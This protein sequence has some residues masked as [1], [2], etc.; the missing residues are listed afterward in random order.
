ML[1]TFTA[2]KCRTFIRIG[3]LVRMD[4]ER[5]IQIAIARNADT[6]AIG[7]RPHPQSGNIFC[8]HLSAG[9]I[10]FPEISPLT[11][12]PFWARRKQRH[13]LFETQ[14]SLQIPVSQH[15][16][17]SR[18]PFYPPTEITS[19]YVQFSHR[20]HGLPSRVHLGVQINGTPV[21]QRCDRDRNL[22]D[23]ETMTWEDIEMIKGW[24]GGKITEL[25][26]RWN[27]RISATFAT[28]IIL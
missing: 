17:F 12:P 24:F 19:N 6:W 5:D 26:P 4:R 20:T 27:I 28:Q 7:P 23:A 16:A 8:S 25:C 21:H 1:I 3:T 11:S 10:L 15:R 2:S 18:H 22:G 14:P 9:V 13:W